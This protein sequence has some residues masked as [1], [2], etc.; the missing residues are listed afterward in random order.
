M[1][2]IKAPIV[3]TGIEHR[4]QKTYLVVLFDDERSK[5]VLQVLST[6]KGPVSTV[7]EP[8]IPGL[9][10][11]FQARISR[12][13]YLSGTAL[14]EVRVACQFPQP[15]PRKGGFWLAS[16]LLQKCFLGRALTSCPCPR[17]SVSLFESLKRAAGFFFVF[18]RLPLRPIWSI[19]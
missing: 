14:P 17:A 11:R 2:S 19:P 10:L 9:R 1:Y 15:T 16:F 6:R 4:A 8:A 13:L 3:D 5:R 7:E 12:I 18:L